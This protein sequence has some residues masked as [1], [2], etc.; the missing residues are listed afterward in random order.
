MKRTSW[1]IQRA[2]LFALFVR[3]LQTRFGGRWLGAFW[4]LLE[5][6]AH[7]TIMLLIFGVARHR[8]LPVVD[9]PVFLLTGLVPF[10]MFRGLALRLMDAVEANRGLFNYRQVR[11]LDPI[12][13]RAA[14]EIVLYSVVYLLM[15]GG[16]GWLGFH[17]L[18]AQPLELMGISVALLA[19]GFGL[20]LIF[21][22]VTEDLPGVRALIRITSMPLYLL[23]GVIF[24]V[25]SL[26]S[27]VL[28]WLLWNPVLH[29]LE[30]SRGYFL[31]EYHALPQFSA[32]Y[33]A[34]FALVVLSLG[35]SLYRVRQLGGS[36]VETGR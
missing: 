10:L 20:G 9:Y 8:V 34:G 18:P 30:L 12:I 21:A 35:M 4:V 22:V 27:S 31:S 17:F 6:L 15:L 2:V 7:L 33:V 26:P 1:Q 24:P 14:L 28:P 13:S 3:E 29:A 32:T 36:R 23:S 5:P 25:S 11:T 16:L 19:A